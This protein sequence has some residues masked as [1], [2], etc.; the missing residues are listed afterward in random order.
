ML[1]TNFKHLGHVVL[2]K[3]IF[4]NISMLFYGSNLGPHGARPS[5]ILG[6]WFEQTW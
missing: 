2:T 1:H 5:W 3:K 6:P 4:E